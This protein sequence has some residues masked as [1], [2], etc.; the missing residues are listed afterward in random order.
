MLYQLLDQ[1]AHAAAFPQVSM[2]GPLRS[3][4][5]W[6]AGRTAKRVREADDPA[7][8]AKGLREFLGLK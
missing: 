1:V 3:P 2:V 6:L 4:S 7:A 5:H 8:A